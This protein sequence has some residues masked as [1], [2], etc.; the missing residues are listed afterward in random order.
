MT[1]LQGSAGEHRLYRFGGSYV[2]QG[3]GV[4][5]YLFFVGD[6]RVAI[7]SENADIGSLGAEGPVLFEGNDVTARLVR[8]IR[9]R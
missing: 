7:Q 3:G 8:S 9:R 4:V 1:V 5:D 2:G 6:N